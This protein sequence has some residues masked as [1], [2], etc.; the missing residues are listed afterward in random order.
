MCLEV[1]T[2][3]RYKRCDTLISTKCQHCSLRP[4]LWKRGMYRYRYVHEIVQNE[5]VNIMIISC[6][7]TM[8]NWLYNRVITKCIIYYLIK[9]VT[10]MLPQCYHCIY[11]APQLYLKSV[12][13][14][15]NHSFIKIFLKWCKFAWKLLMRSIIM[16]APYNTLKALLY[17]QCIK[18]LDYIST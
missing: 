2:T 7:R 6:T 8:Y 5:T 13:L 11:F 3:Q 9:N 1:K 18:L 15:I 16:L 12:N 4:L 10:T 14:R 17:I